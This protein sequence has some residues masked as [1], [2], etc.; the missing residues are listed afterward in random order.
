MPYMDSMAYHL[1]KLLET[2][3][4][5]KLFSG[6]GVEKN[7]VAKSIVLKK[8]NNWDAAADSLKLESRQWD[9]REKEHMKRTNTKRNS[10]YWEHELEEERTDIKHRDD[11]ENISL[12]RQV[13][14]FSGLKSFSLKSLQT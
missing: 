14:T 8:S 13:S 7:N 5:V 1:P 11:M 10:E 4:T 12:C 9:L 3:K 2:Y 6:Q